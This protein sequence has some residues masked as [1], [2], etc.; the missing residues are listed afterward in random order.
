[1]RTSFIVT[2]I[3]AAS[4]ISAFAPNA[5]ADTECYDRLVCVTQSAST[6]GDGGCAADGGWSGQS[7]YARIDSPMVPGLVVYSYNGCSAYDDGNTEY[8]WSWLYLNAYYAS[9]IAGFYLVNAGWS[10]GSGATAH[11]YAY[12]FTYFGPLSG[13]GYG[14][15]CNAGDVNPEP[16][17]LLGLLP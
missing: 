12:Y 16:P 1:M 5:S 7:H 4:A 15:P 17:V 2:M 14:R 9:P 13:S 11:C 6:W 3:I 10:G 8:T